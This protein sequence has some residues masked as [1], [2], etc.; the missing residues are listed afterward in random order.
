MP[1]ASQLT[2]DIKKALKSRDT[3][4]LATLRYAL[5]AIRRREVDE[6]RSLEDSEVIQVLTKLVHQHEE[7]A[8]AFRKAGRERDVQAAEEE[9]RV[10]S[11]YLPPRLEEAELLAVIDRVI[12]ETH[13]LKPQDIGRVMG[14][15]K[16]E[17]SGRADLAHVSAEVKARLTG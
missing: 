5:A 16:V 3:I 8:E 15:L 14:R 6:R 7:S 1:I 17:L 11:T 12:A 10:V 2:D 9:I 4:R 13:A